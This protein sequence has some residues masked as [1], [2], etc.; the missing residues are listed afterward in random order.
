MKCM[1][2]SEKDIIHN[3]QI[4]K[5]AQCYDFS[6]EDA[7]DLTEK[8]FVKPIKLLVKELEDML[9]DDSIPKIVVPEIGIYKHPSEIAN[10][11]V[12]DKKNKLEEPESI[13]AELAD[14][15]DEILEMEDLVDELPP[16][17]KPAT[18][19]KTKKRD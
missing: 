15:E 2:V 1:V 12:L 10:D 9:D 11:K 19:K 13:V 18:K 5:H 17:K 8:G 14:D 4:L 3:G 7:R 16:K 6:A